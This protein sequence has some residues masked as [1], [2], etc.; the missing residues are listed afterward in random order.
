METLVNSKNMFAV[1]VQINSQTIIR[2]HQAG[3][4]SFHRYLD[5]DFRF[6]VWRPVFNGITDEVEQHLPQ[7][8][9]VAAFT[10]FAARHPG[11]FQGYRV[12]VDAQ[13]D[14]PARY[15][16]MSVPTIVVLRD[17]REIARLDGLIRETDLEDVLRA[18]SA[19]A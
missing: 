13:P 6:A 17:G 9:R 7:A 16:V 8:E 3:I 2:N 19:G 11:E 15:D 1:S 4:I 12:D 14:A 10:E 5:I 18:A